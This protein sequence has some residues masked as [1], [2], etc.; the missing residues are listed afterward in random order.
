MKGVGMPV[1][2]EAGWATFICE[3]GL[4]DGFFLM[5]SALIKDKEYQDHHPKLGSRI[6]LDLEPYPEG[7]IAGR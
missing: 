7:R 2:I 5:Q 6:S 1:P 4:G 3:T